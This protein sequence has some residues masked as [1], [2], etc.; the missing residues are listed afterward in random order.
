MRRIKYW[1]G[2]VLLTVLALGADSLGQAAYNKDVQAQTISTSGNS[3][4][5]INGIGALN[6]VF[7]FI[8]SGSPTTLTITT[9]GCMRSGTC[10]TLD[11]YLQ[12]SSANRKVTGLYDNFKVTASW[13]GGSS[14]TVKANY[15]GSAASSP[16]TL[17]LDPCASPGVT[18]SSAVLNATATAVLLANTAGQQ[19]FICSIT[20]TG[21]GTTPSIQ[22]EF[23]TGATCGTGTTTLS[24][25]MLPT[26]G[27]VLPLGYGGAIYTLPASNDF[28]AVIAGTT[29]SWQ[30]SIFYVKQ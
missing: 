24:G 7:E 16:G 10:D 5:F 12:T 6:E 26:A 8:V 18:K 9:Q 17:N 4:T 15:L 14:P 3:I 13:T 29:P 25:V 28:C 27:Q 22:F 23:G 1:L 20:A 11:T 2:L 19:I 30:G 21:G